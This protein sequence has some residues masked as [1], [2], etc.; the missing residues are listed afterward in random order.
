MPRR[1]TYNIVALIFASM[2][3][4]ST[5]H[6]KAQAPDALHTPA[7]E[8]V[9][10]RWINTAGPIELHSRLG[11]VTVVEFFT[12]DCINCRRNLPTYAA[13]TREFGPEGVEV[14]GIHTP[15]TKWE[16]GLGFVKER[17]REY[18][19]TYPVVTDNA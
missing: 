15:E 7:P 14:I 19:I 3:L 8:I 5:F 11:K 1:I 4:L 2:L 9:G 18:G 10:G 12:A 6:V 17:V 13:W 16:A